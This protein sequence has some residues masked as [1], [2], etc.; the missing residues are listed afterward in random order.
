MYMFLLLDI[1]GSRPEII[2]QLFWV[3]QEPL[4]KKINKSGSTI[5]WLKYIYGIA[6]SYNSNMKHEREN[7]EHLS[8]YSRDFMELGGDHLLV[9]DAG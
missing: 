7:Q 4:G 1:S 9:F 2:L 3:S 6:M 5:K 8:I